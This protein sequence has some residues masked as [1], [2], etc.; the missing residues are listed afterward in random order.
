MFILGFTFYGHYSWSVVLWMLWYAGYVYGWKATRWW[1]TQCIKCLKLIFVW[2]SQSWPV[3]ISRPWL[4]AIWQSAGFWLSISYLPAGYWL[5]AGYWLAMDWLSH[6]HGLAMGWLCTD[7]RL[8]SADYRLAMG[9]L[10][11][12]WLMAIYRQAMDWLWVGYQLFSII[13]GLATRWLWLAIDWLWADLLLIQ[14][15]LYFKSI[16]LYLSVSQNIFKTTGQ[17]F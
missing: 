2:F 9:W 10:S 15:Q 17:P 5:S 12:G 14:W 3:L 13:Y 16:E 11:M 4:S 6:I 1:H 8:V 7:Y